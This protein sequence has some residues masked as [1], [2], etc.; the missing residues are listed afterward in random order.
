ISRPAITWTEPSASILTAVV[1]PVVL[2]PFDTGGSSPGATREPKANTTAVVKALTDP[3]ISSHEPSAAE[4]C[5]LTTPPLMTPNAQ[6][7]TSPCAVTFPVNLPQVST[8]TVP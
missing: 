6:A 8:W 3:R 2:T 5:R 7:A 4:P 1:S